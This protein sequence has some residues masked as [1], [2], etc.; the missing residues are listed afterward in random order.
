LEMV[1]GDK[2]KAAALLGIS[3]ITLWRILKG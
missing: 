2:R 1:D 3:E